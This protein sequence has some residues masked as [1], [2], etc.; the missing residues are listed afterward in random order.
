MK[1]KGT[2]LGGV[3]IGAALGLLFAPK[4]GSELRKDLSL[5]FNDL[6]DQVKKMDKDDFVDLINSKIDDLKNEIE[7]LDKE[8]VLKK[9]KDAS[10]VVKTKSEEL[11]KLAK[12]KGNEEIVKTTEAL[13][14]KAL[15]VA[16]DVVDKLEKK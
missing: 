7:K 2:L 3:A 13:R 6:F 15:D 10:K 11:V 5:K 9:A 8:T 14:E 12:K 1:K 4:K 16:K